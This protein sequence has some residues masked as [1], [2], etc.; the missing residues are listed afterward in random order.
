MS[1]SN[2]TIKIIK[3]TVPVLEVHGAT[4]TKVFYKNMLTEHPELLNM[5]NEVNQ[6]EGKQQQALANLVYAAAQNIDQLENVLAEVQLVANKHRGLGVK[7]EHYPIVGKY[8]LLAIKEVLGDAATD[9]I[10]NA[11]EEAY[12]L[13]AQVFIDIESKM[14]QETADQN[15]GWDGFKDFIVTDKVKESDVITSFYLKAKDNKELAD[16]KTGQYLTVRVTI[17]NET[18]MQIRHYTISAAPGTDT[19]RIS[20]KKETDC[21]PNGKVSTYLHDLVHVGDTIEASA[22]SGTFIL[23]E[24]NR[25]ITLISGGVGITPMIS[26]LETLSSKQSTQVINFVHSARNHSVHAFH[27]HVSGLVSALPNAK[28]TYGYSDLNSAYQ[29]DFNGY[30]TKETLEQ[31]VKENTICYVV[32]PVPFMKHVANLLS[33]LGL[34]EANI[35]YELFGPAQD[36]LEEIS[37]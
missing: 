21:T 23:E 20:V 2:E 12:G 5:F 26:M 33:E 29:G 37:I 27:D 18:Y 10:M 8:L 13:I 3:S 17:P 35:R 16:Y 22:P 24:S 34:S 30:L 7:P 25:P 14:Y 11:W 15:G 1:L 28:Y 19:Y 36:I 6:K 32:G 4:I 31:A 9:E